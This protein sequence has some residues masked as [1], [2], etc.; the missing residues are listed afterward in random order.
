LGGGIAPRIL[1]R[2]KSGPFLAA[3]CD[4]EKFESWMG[5]VPVKVITNDRCA[6][7]GAANYI[8]QAGRFLRG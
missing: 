7:R 1:P 8:I 6:L 3:F 4:K 5:A 2:L